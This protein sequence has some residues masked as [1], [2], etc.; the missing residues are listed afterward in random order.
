MIKN[1][2]DR[3]Q[4][5]EMYGWGG[6]LDGSRPSLVSAG[7]AKLADLRHRSTSPMSNLVNLGIPVIRTEGS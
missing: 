3:F 7:R 6:D 4:E 2:Q 5:V 1:L